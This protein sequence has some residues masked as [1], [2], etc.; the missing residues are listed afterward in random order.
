[1]AMTSELRPESVQPHFGQAQATRIGT[2]PTGLSFVIN[3]S[4]TVQDTYGQLHTNLERQAFFDEFLK[5][6][7]R[8]FPSAWVAIYETVDLIRQADW[9]W[10][11]QGFD[12]FD[13]FWQEQGAALFGRW[14]DLEST[15]Q[16]A[17]LAAPHLFEVQYE[18]AKAMAMELAQFRQVP[19]AAD[20]HRN[21]KAGRPKKSTDDCP[22]ISDSPVEP[23]HYVKEMNSAEWND[24]FQQGQR[25]KADGGNSR[26]AR[27]A[28]LRRDNPEVADRFLAGEFVKRFKDGTVRPDLVA[29]EIAAGIRKEGERT[30]QRDGLS[31]VRKLIASFTR[32]ELV[33]LGNHITTLLEADQ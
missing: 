27:F 20:A 10:K 19:A 1:M 32:E 11:G 4:E 17:H 14:A 33:S 28:R 21:G 13:A 29:A 3:G 23:T 2:L 5:T 18:E 25:A 16:Y 7:R 22:S 9:Y 24:G 15:Y 12:S 8:G 6:Q 26:F 31:Y 30:R